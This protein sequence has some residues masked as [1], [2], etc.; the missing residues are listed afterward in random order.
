VRANVAVAEKFGDSFVGFT[1]EL[2]ADRL[3]CKR[4]G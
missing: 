2:P 4:A 1:R 3:V